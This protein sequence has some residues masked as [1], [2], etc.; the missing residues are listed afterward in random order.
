VTEPSPRLKTCARCGTILQAS[1]GECRT[2]H[3]PQPPAGERRAARD[4]TAAGGR[5]P[6]RPLLVGLVASVLLAAAGYGLYT[7]REQ[8]A[9]RLSAGGASG[10]ATGDATGGAAAAD[11]ITPVERAGAGDAFDFAD[12]APAPR[13]EAQLERVLAHYHVEG[14]TTIEVFAS[15]DAL[16]PDGP[17]GKA[18]GLTELQSGTYEYV[19]DRTS[20]R[21]VVTSLTARLTITLPQLVTTPLPLSLDES[22]RSYLRAVAEHE[23]RHAD[24]F[25]EA[26]DRVAERLRSSQPF[27]DRTAMEAGFEAAWTA[28]MAVAEH[29]NAEFHRREAQDT[30]FEREV[31]GNELA[32]VERELETL[33]ARLQE[34]SRRYPDLHLPLEEYAQHESDRLRYDALIKERAGLI[35]RG[36]WLH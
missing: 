10:R 30:A 1:D 24:I 35:E 8:L 4:E 14:R 5:S 27:A 31:V 36:L 34:R 17:Q 23:Q 2:C 25:A 26:V 32:R 29:S 3:A 20:A 33:S 13:V 16:G 6:V 18:V 15:I 11:A 9:R 12:G 19:Q 21:C 28:E 22:W 7:V